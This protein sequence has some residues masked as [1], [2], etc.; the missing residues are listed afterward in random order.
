VRIG[1]TVVA[2]QP[3]LGVVTGADGAALVG[4]RDTLLSLP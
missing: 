2:H 4:A 3:V 1:D